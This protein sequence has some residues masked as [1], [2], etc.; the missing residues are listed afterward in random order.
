MSLKYKPAKFSNN[1]LYFFQIYVYKYIQPSL[2][3][4]DVTKP[5]LIWQ[6]MYLFHSSS[7]NKAMPLL[8]WSTGQA[9]YM[10]RQE[11]IL[12]ERNRTDLLIDYLKQD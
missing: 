3:T 7:L 12:V 2:I 6:E 5:T 1:L 11:L 8:Y 9:T 10:V 4:G